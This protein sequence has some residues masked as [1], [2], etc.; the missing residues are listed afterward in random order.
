M[1]S[2][3]VVIKNFRLEQKVIK[4]SGT[5]SLKTESRNA[6]AVAAT[7]SV[8]FRKSPLAAHFSRDMTWRGLCQRACLKL[9]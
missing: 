1:Q 5:E 8:P 7:G 9:R 2:S 4:T 3:K 6:A